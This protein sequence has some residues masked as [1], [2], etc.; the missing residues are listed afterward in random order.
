MRDWQKDCFDLFKDVR[1]GTCNAF[2]GS[3]KSLLLIALGC[4]QAIESNGTRK[5]LI[6]TVQRNVAKGFVGTPETDYVKLKIDDQ[7]VTWKV[8]ATEQFCDEKSKAVLVRLKNW[9]LWRPRPGNLRNNI[10]TGI[11]AV[12]SH[13]AFGRV[14]QN[15]TR[16][17]RLLAIQNLSLYID[18]GHHVKGVF[19]E[20]EG[21]SAAEKIYMQETATLL[22]SA[23]RFIVKHR[24]KVSTSRLY[25]ASATLFRSDDGIL[26]SPNIGKLFTAYDLPFDQH[27]RFLQIPGFE[28]L[29]EDYGLD[30]IEQ[31]VDN[32]KLD[33]RGSHTIFVPRENESWR[34]GDPTAVQRL[35]DGLSAEVP[36]AQVLD[37]VDQ[38]PAIRREAIQRLRLEPKTP[39]DGKPKLRI[40]V[41]CRVGDEGMDWCPCDRV[42]LT[43]PSSSLTRTI[44]MMMRP[45]RKYDGKG[46]VFIHTYIRAIPFM[47]DNAKCRELLSDRTN[48]ILVVMF[49]NEK[50]APILI[51]VPKKAGKASG[52]GRGPQSE[53]AASAT[54]E[55]A[56]HGQY[57]S[58]KR[59]M[60]KELMGLRSYTSSTVDR[61][62]NGVLRKYRVKSTKFIQEGMHVLTLRILGRNSPKLQGVDVSFLR[63]QGFDKI[64]F[65]YK[66]HRAQIYAGVFDGEID[67]EKV[68][69]LFE[70]R[71]DQQARL[72]YS[73]K[74]NPRDTHELTHEGVR[75]IRRN[76]K[77]KVA[78]GD[79][80]NKVK[81]HL[82]ALYPDL[83]EG[84]NTALDLMPL[85][86]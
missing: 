23:C 50:F 2:G 68:R 17:E 37:L 30:P 85:E 45:F 39:Y 59:D 46:R 60:L 49:L 63:E 51:E 72:V 57:E 77:K 28:M 79:A 76:W 71:V 80:A 73:R 35:I 32:V 18:E 48:A 54:L 83:T 55:A 67:Y 62:I 70:S 16:A 69:E 58:A 20:D 56:F 38:T 19:E 7:T 10:I 11:C 74:F 26:L 8:A 75:A 44:Q 47:G 52:G 4:H 86:S 29:Y 15:L 81:T 14:W 22:G 78:S 82:K 64:V 66:L 41:T 43:N 3:G 25:L 21:Y 65:R 53:H 36:A 13:H 34:A 27:W 24:R 6:L 1:F 40:I 33:L 61:V 84:R 12:A 31:I 5:Q 9:L 42:H